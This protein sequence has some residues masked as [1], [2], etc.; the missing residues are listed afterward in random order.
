MEGIHDLGGKQGF[1]PVLSNTF[2]KKNRVS[3][4]FNERWHGAVFTI[5]HSLF[6]NG[7]AANTDH[8]R[9]SVARIDPI[10]YLSEGYYG[11]WLGAAETLLVEA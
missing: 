5:I 8:V 3:S 4:G 1:G 2:S 7:T 6:A 10:N 11:R 9:P